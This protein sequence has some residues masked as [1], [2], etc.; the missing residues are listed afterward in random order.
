MPQ[1][2][3][4]D[5]AV[6]QI[7]PLECVMPAVLEQTVPCYRE[8]QYSKTNIF[9]PFLITVHF[10]RVHHNACK[11]CH[12]FGIDLSTGKFCHREISKK[13]TVFHGQQIRDNGRAG[14][15]ATSVRYSATP[16]LRYLRTIYMVA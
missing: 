1:E 6:G 15:S 3:I 12:R 13:K 14:R 7:V 4:T 9:L 16:L 10:A 11:K 2:I 5:R 8:N